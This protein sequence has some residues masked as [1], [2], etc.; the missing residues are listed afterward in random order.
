MRACQ[1]ILKQMIRP[2]LLD[3]YDVLASMFEK[4]QA[5]IT[6]I[7]DNLSIANG[8]IHESSEP[9]TSSTSDISAHPGPFDARRILPNGFLLRSSRKPVIDVVPLPLILQDHLSDTHPKKSDINRLLSQDHLQ[10]LYSRF[11]GPRARS[12][13]MVEFD[14]SASSASSKHPSQSD[15]SPCGGITF[16]IN[17]HIWGFTTAVSNIWVGTNYSKSLGYLPRILLRLHLA[18]ERE[19]RFKEYVRNATLEKSGTTDQAVADETVPT[20][21]KDHHHAAAKEGVQLPKMNPLDIRGMSA[22]VCG[23]QA[24]GDVF[25]AG[26]A[27]KDTIDLPTNKDELAIFLSG[28][29]VM[30]FMEL[31]KYQDRIKVQLRMR[32]SISAME[33]PQTPAEG[34]N[35]RDH[36]TRRQPG[37]ASLY[38]TSQGN[39]YKK[40]K[41]LGYT[42]VSTDEYKTSSVCPRYNSATNRVIADASSTATSL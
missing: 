27:C 42:I 34:E 9:G 14:S 33:S 11:L 1:D 4:R 17:E 26:A 6:N 15:T 41:A 10:P 22:M 25:L 30:L 8:K 21:K 20:S 19:R 35:I 23:L 37:L 39:F 40:P 31:H 16:T 5:D 12:K 7:I 36:H 24:E 13:K 38:T 18:P 3:H 29:S 28:P 2:D 32:Y